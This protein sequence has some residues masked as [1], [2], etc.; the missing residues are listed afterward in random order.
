MGPSSGSN[1]GLQVWQWAPW[2]IKL[3]DPLCLEPRIVLRW[4][5][6][7][8]AQTDWSLEFRRC[9]SVSWSP[10]VLFWSLV[11]LG[12]HLLPILGSLEGTPCSWYFSPSWYV[13]SWD[14]FYALYIIP[15]GLFNLWAHILPFR[16]LWNYFVDN[17][18]SSAFFHLHRILGPDLSFLITLLVLTSLVLLFC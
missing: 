3:I 10:V 14:P 7:C 5:I 2:A 8:Y 16:C 4:G 1:S 11:L 13:L 9:P 17:L 15:C 18:R 6:C 12:K